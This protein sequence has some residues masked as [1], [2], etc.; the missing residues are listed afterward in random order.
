MDPLRPSLIDPNLSIKSAIWALT[1]LSALFL[2][3]RLY[4]RRR[5]SGF[6]WDDA[7]LAAA[8]TALLGYVV[9]VTII[10][11]RTTSQQSVRPSGPIKLK[12]DDLNTVAT[13]GLC[14]ATLAITAQSWSKTSFAITLLR[15]SDGWLKRF[16]WF[17][18]G[19]MNVLFGLRALFLWIGC[20]PLEKSWHPRVKGS[21]WDPSVD[22]VL[23][24]VIS[25]MLCLNT[26]ALGNKFL[27][28]RILPNYTQHTRE[29]WISYL[30]W[31][32][33]RSSYH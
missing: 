28:V 25:G 14:S 23:G 30:P 17:A 13:L 32:R 3:L 9:V 24:V 15:I 6:H 10:L 5:G 11:E 16:L 33:G 20:S 21:C 31:S 18:I 22:V 1:I 12:L 26:P 29:L 19:S 8:W 7:I 4:C 27:T 2:A